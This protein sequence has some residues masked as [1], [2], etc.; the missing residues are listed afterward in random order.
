MPRKTLQTEIAEHLVD[1]VRAGRMSRRELIVRGSVAGLGVTSLGSL[2]AACGGG[3]S[4]GGGGGTAQAPA[5]RGGTLRLSIPVPAAA[6]EPVTMFDGSSIALVQQLAEYLAWVEPDLQLRPVL[7]ERW[8]PSEDAKTWTFA[9]RQGVK[10]ND[11]SPLT[12]ADVK[13]SFDRLVDPKSQS[14]ALS[15]FKG[16]LSAGQI[17]VQGGN[18][19]F[20]LDSPFADFPYLVSSA[21][22]NALVLP[23]DYD[24]DFQ[25]RPVGTGPFLMDQFVPKRSATM[26]R[27]P[28]YWQKGRPFLDGATFAFSEDVQAEV[29]ALQANKA[30]VMVISPLQGT[31]ALA[32]NSKFAFSNLP[33][34]GHNALSMRVDKPPFDDVR[35]RQAL[36]LATD[37]EQMQT[38]LYQGR[39]TIG[40][41]TPFAPAFPI[42]PKIA[43]PARDVAKAKEL[44]AQAGHPNGFPITLS[45]ERA[46]EIPQQATLYKQ[47]W[48]DIGVDVT[49]DIQSQAAYYGSGA[50]Q[51]WLEVTLGL[52]DWAGRAVPAQYLIPAYTSDGIWNSAH[53][54]DPAF[55]KLVAGF[56][57]EVLPGDVGRT[58]L[59]PYATPA[60][61]QALDR[62]LG[63]DR[64]LVVR[65]GD[66][67]GG[68]VTGDWGVSPVDQVAVR[69]LVLDRLWASAQLA[70]VALALLVPLA[71][72]FGVL[73]GL[74]AGSPTDRSITVFGLTFAAI[75][76]FVS[77]V[78]LLIAFA[79]WLPLFPVSAEFA[80]GAG[81]LDRLWHLLLP[82][83]PL[84]LVS[85]GYVSRMARSG[86]LV[87][88]R[89]PWART[90]ELK[91]L[92]RGQVLRRH[93]LPNALLPTVTVLGAQ[94]GWLVGGRVV[95]ETLFNYPGIGRLLL[96]SATGKDI[97]LLEAT[98]VV[99]AAVVILANLLADVL[100]A[101]LDPRVRQGRA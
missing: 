82:A 80:A 48:K 18:V 36:A 17:A 57:A 5:K 65:Y 63:V 90:A 11:G 3:D 97:P 24:G 10:F 2:L 30:D 81:P 16:I 12:P 61:V 27:N 88:V 4:G 56:N 23:K 51:P 74:R 58:I 54:K 47:Q 7:A 29:L 92:P 87:A 78:F 60:Q 64:S 34:S 85:F 69:P 95:T 28:Q 9:I 101:V 44:L 66:W 84:A 37:R 75:P 50:N 6:L 46:S 99:I 45:T 76:E 96:D 38:V 68:F 98:A 72:G 31:R 25:K 43:P 73:A 93:L 70:L 39:G 13:A 62:E 52:V 89:A 55:D 32:A 49:L 79:V 77:G 40:N 100:A 19:V 14:A 20:N 86:T 53:W 1:E 41:D 83:V 33:S 67:L 91:G 8:E 22:Y 59:G 42:S 15:N 71:I 21:N 35:V 94:V 26:R